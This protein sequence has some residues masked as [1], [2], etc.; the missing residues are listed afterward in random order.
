MLKCFNLGITDV[1]KDPLTNK[2]QRLRNKFPTKVI[3]NKNFLNGL[4]FIYYSFYKI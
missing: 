3:F 1:I 4:E 2:Y